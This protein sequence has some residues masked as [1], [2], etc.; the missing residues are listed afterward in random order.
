MRRA[1]VVCMAVFYPSAAFA[2]GSGFPG[3]KEAVCPALEEFQLEIYGFG[4]LLVANPN[5]ELGLPF[6]AT[7]RFATSS[8]VFHGIVYPINKG[9]YGLELTYEQSS[10]GCNPLG[11]AYQK[12]LRLDQSEDLANQVYYGVTLRRRK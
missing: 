1:I 11:G 8:V 6:R 12:Q 2:D 7:R 9:E 10:P 4:G 3:G 5:V